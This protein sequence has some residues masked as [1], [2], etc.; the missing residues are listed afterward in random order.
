MAQCNGKSRMLSVSVVIPLYNHGKYIAETLY[1]V[2]QQSYPA[3]EIIVVD[4]GSKDGCGSIVE[5]LAVNNKNII[6]WRQHNRGAHNAINAGVARATSDIVLILNSDDIYHRDRLMEVERAFRE[7]DADAVFTDIEYCDGDSKPI[8]FEWHR[9]AMADYKNSKIFDE[10][11]I[12]GNF[13]ATTSNIAFRRDALES[14][15]GFSNLR[16]AHDLDFFLRLALQDR[17]VVHIERPL[18]SYRLHGS[19]T[20][21]EGH[22]RVRLEW[23]AVTGWY[24]AA[25]ARQKGWGEITRFYPVLERHSLLRPLMPVVAYFYD[26]QATTT[27]GHHFFEDADFRSALAEIL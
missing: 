9:N 2:L 5:S 20:I 26:S 17:K 12:N 10:S 3:N 14:I 15:G 25:L 27:E 22:D 1:S 11:L 21:S 19:N 18:M 4:D 6:F 23:V 7:Q 24:L 8:D 13:I 16:Y